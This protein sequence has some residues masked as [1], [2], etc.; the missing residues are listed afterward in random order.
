MAI[1]IRSLTKLYLLEIVFCFQLF[2]LSWVKHFISLSVFDQDLQSCSGIPQKKIFTS[3]NLSH[4]AGF[5]PACPESD[6]KR[7][8]AWASLDGS[9]FFHFEEQFSTYLDLVH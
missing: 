3:S 4:Q 8:K 7:L 6:S 9:Y 1:E 5:P 2:Q